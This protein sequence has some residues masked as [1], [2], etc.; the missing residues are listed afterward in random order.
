MDSMT[1]A[2]AGTLV[3]KTGFNQRNLPPHRPGPRHIFWNDDLLA[4]LPLT[5]CSGSTNRAELSE[6]AS[7]AFDLQLDR[8]L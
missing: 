5:V 4:S 6:A 1:H 8:K 7:L 2:L 3:A